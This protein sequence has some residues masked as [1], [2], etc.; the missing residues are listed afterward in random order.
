MGVLTLAIAGFGIV[1]AGFLIGSQNIGSCP[2]NQSGCDHT[3]S[4]TDIRI[5]QTA[6]IIMLIGLA[7]LAAAL[8]VGVYNR[9]TK[10]KPIRN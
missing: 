6:R 7:I 4:G 10:T 1:I 3:F 5:G 9:M 8:A 2:A